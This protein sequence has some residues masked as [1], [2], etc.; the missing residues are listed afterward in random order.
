M[1]N[2]E[3]QLSKKYTFSSITIKQ[4]YDLISEDKRFQVL[5]VKHKWTF[6][7][8]ILRLAN[9]TVCDPITVMDQ[10]T[11]T[12]YSEETFEKIEKLKAPKFRKFELISCGTCKYVDQQNMEEI[13]G[14]KK[15]I[16]SKYPD[17][18]PWVDTVCNGWEDGKIIIKE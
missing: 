15:Y 7:E 3:E 6:A 5:S 11:K 18:E 12:Y 17:I 9:N 2:I 1:N 8:S 4:L 10:L 14:C 16:T 13:F